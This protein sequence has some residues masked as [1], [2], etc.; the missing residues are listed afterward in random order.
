MAVVLGTCTVILLSD[1]GQVHSLG[2]NNYG[3]LGLGHDDTV[4]VTNPLPNLIPN[5]P[6]IK[7]ISCG[8]HF[9]ICLDYE[10]FIWAFG[11][12]KKG[13][14]GTG[15]TTNFNVPQQ[16]LNIP[17]VLS[18]ACG[19]EH[20]LI[21]TNDDN[22]WS[23]GSNVHG[24][25]CLGNQENQTTFQKTSFSNISRIS[26]AT[27]SLFQNHKEEI[28]SC[29]ANKFGEC[30]L[31]HF[32]PQ[33]QPT[34]I[35]NLPPNIIQFV[36]GVQQSFFLDS[37]GN[38]FSVGDNQYGE[39]GLGHNNKQN[40][41]NRIPNIPPIQNISC[42]FHFIYLLDKEGNVWTCGFNCYGQLGHGDKT[43]RTVP[44]M[45]KDLKDIRQ[46]SKGPISNSFYAK[47]SQGKIFVTGY[48]GNG[49]LC[50]GN[51]RTLFTP[52]EIDSQFFSIWGDSIPNSKSKS[53]RK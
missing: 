23:C 21:I 26:V 31:G 8:M 11:Q 15:N 27:H 20:T 37:D 35:P 47:D 38:V 34:L 5:L 32:N 48:N 9:A 52:K 51:T 29:G 16:I 36:C 39:L 18:V 50:T 33:V 7:Q 28:Y 30:A 44:T 3:Q 13:Q 14:L 10:G 19:Y 45:I 43:N 22:L 12:N 40:V 24:Q 41:L 1:D 42:G 17:P 4:S 2:Q 25:L 6:K 53:A 49:Q 46:I